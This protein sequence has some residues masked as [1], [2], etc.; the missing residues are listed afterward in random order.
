MKNRQAGVTLIELM[1]ALGILG[2][3]AAV[4]VPSFREYTRNTRVQAASNDLFTALSLAR[5]ESLRRG[6]PV[7]VC[8][9]TDSETCEGSDNWAT[10]FILFNDNGAIAGEIDGDEVVLQAWPGY[11]PEVIISAE[12][13]VS[14]L[15]YLPTGMIDAA[16]TETF[17]VST[18]GCTGPKAREISVTV[19]G[20]PSSKKVDCE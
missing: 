10:G 20:S 1:T 7:A 18:S 13:D 19:V 2:I 4:A 6:Q 15:R 14:S 3:L 12:E 8:A 16:G 17:R 11:P 5:S 9:S